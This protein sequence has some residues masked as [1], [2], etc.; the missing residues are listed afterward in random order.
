[1]KKIIALLLTLG[2]AIALAACTETA[3]LEPEETTTAEITTEAEETTEP[4][5]SHV[6]EITLYRVTDI[7]GPVL[8]TV[9]AMTDGTPEHVAQLLGIQEIRSFENGVLDLPTGFRQATGSLHELAH[10]AA[11]GNTFLT[12]FELDYMFFTGGTDFGHFCWG[13]SDEACDCEPFTY[14]A[15]FGLVEPDET[16]TTMQ[17]DTQE[18]QLYLPN[19]DA[20]GFRNITVQTSGTA[21]HIVQLL[22]EHGALPQGSQALRFDG[23][24]LDMNTAF[25]QTLSQMGSAGEFMM[26]GSLVNTI[27]GFFELESITITV[28]DETLETGHEI[29]DYPLTYFTF[30]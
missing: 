28:E 14:D 13:C 10:R 2:L 17:T 9:Q 27:L 12:F 26:L 18:I 16:T 22:V 1:M 19:E 15:S 8:Y 20:S 30:G 3:T 5:P 4:D 29:Y 6:Y 21:W 11:I 23:G 24:V 25:A 7:G